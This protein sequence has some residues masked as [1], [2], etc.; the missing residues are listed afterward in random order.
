MKKILKITFAFVLS[1]FMLLFFSIFDNKAS[2]EGLLNEKGYTVCYPNTTTP[3]VVPEY[4]KQDTEFRAAW[5]SF[6]AG[7]ISSY[8]SDEHMKKQLLE[9]LNTLEDYHM[10]AIVFHI[11][12]HNDAMYDTSLA[13]QSSYVRGMDYERFDYLEWFI[14]ECHKRGIEFHA[15]LNPYRISNGTTMDAILSKYKDYENN[16]AHKKENILINS[17]GEAILDPGVVEVQDYI[18]D[19]CMEVIE[20]YDVDAIHFDDYFYIS[21][22]DDS[23]TRKKYNKTGLSL[24]DFRR[25]SVDDF[26][27]KLSTS[28]YNYNIA[29]NRCVQLGIS[30]SGIYDNYGSSYISPNSYKWDTSG[31]LSYPLGS[32]TRGYAHYG[33]PLYCDT[34]KWIDNEWIDYI[35]PQVYFSFD[36]SSAC[37]ASIVE[38]WNAVVKNKNVNLYIGQAL[39]KKSAGKGEGW[40]VNE[41]E[42]YNQ[43]RFNQKCGYVDG[44][45]VY[46]YK[47]LTRFD[48]TIGNKKVKNECFT[49]DVKLPTLLRY[50]EN[51]S[52]EL[53]VN[54]LKLFRAQ[55]DTVLCWDKVE[56]AKNYLIYQYSISLD[57]TNP[58]QIIGK[59]GND[60][61]QDYCVFNFEYDLSKGSNFAVIPLNEANELCTEEVININQVSDFDK[62]DEVIS[63]NE[64]FVTGVI[65]GGAKL[66]LRFYD[67]TIKFGT[68]VNYKVL[69]V[70]DYVWNDDN[71]EI[72]NVSKTADTYIA[73]FQMDKYCTPITLKI[74]AETEFGSSLSE[75]IH[76]NLTYD[77]ASSL[78]KNFFIIVN[79]MI[80]NLYGE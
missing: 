43:L 38:W 8:S 31:N 46:Q 10:N 23:E 12:T 33:S 66:N 73:S 67:A 69:M 47:S 74:L 50:S 61:N 32:I 41:D 62:E 40:D 3:I 16:P 45:C 52:N 55:N 20:K 19:V 28:M 22:V 11:R 51:V 79:D 64:Y 42:W 17:D 48:N 36:T 1:F 25:K 60:D 24:D 9:V 72:L 21:G 26:I 4:K 59:T 57:L 44:I 29:N 18:V 58:L 13:P 7:D 14:N 68:K 76:I 5:V 63:F 75:E 2:A 80:D 27:Y 30:P 54:N 37:Y 56:M 70:R 35:I 34:K 53:K 39:Y 78:F 71:V 65:L 6:F 49:N 77:N 15:W